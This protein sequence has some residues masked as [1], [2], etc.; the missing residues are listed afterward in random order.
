MNRFVLKIP[1]ILHTKKQ[2]NIANT[3]AVIESQLRR[4]PGVTEEE[5][6]NDIIGFTHDS[7]AGKRV[8]AISQNHG[9]RDKR[10][11]ADTKASFKKYMP[12][13]FKMFP[14]MASPFVGDIEF[15]AGFHNSTEAHFIPKPQPE[16]IKPI[17]AT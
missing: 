2:L 11:Q 1:A 10:V 4:M 12:E 17:K 15:H 5:R 13:I 14:E 16:T 3:L 7:T 8:L 6:L 9:I